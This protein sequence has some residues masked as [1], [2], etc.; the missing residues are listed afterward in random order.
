MAS[1]IVDIASLRRALDLTCDWG[2]LRLFSRTH[3]R[4][5]VESETDQDVCAQ[6]IFCTGTRR[7]SVPGTIFKL[8]KIKII[9]LNNCYTIFEFYLS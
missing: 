9:T 3:R 2:Q 1:N 4:P 5:S 8:Y 6:C 7:Y